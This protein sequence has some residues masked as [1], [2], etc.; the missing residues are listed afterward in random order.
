MYSEQQTKGRESHPHRRQKTQQDSGQTLKSSC[1]GLGGGV[2][3][4]RLPESSE[5]V[6]LLEFRLGSDLGEME[7]QIDFEIE[8]KHVLKDGEKDFEE[9]ALLGE[10]QE[11]TPD[12]IRCSIGVAGVHDLLPHGPEID[13]EMVC[14]ASK[15]RKLPIRDFDRRP[16]V[17][18]D[19][20]TRADGLSDRL[21]LA[22]LGRAPAAV[23]R[24]HDRLQQTLRTTAR[25]G[26][27]DER[28]E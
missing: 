10:G 26:G 3:K 14:I 22:V 9:P 19:R 13:L 25:S 7:F 27:M 15:S 17:Q 6:F 18:E 23:H 28:M 12:D 20:K 16:E 8:R 11:D 1:E 2:W 24:S 5:D 4:V 21:L